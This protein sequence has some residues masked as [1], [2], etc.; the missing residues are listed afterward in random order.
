MGQFLR[1]QR[2]KNVGI[3]EN[4]LDRLKDSFESRVAL[5]NIGKQPNDPAIA[6]LFYIIRFDEKGYRFVNFDDVKKCFREARDVERIVFT[7]D[8]GLNRSSGPIF[9]THC[10]MRFDA[11]DPNACWLSVTADNKDWVD[12]T[13]VNITEVLDGQKTWSRLVRTPWTALLV[14][15]AGV[16]VGFVLSLWAAQKI[17][18]FLSIDNAFVVVLFFS[19]LIY[20]NVWGYIN[21]QIGR[22][23]DFSFPNVRFKR[24]GKDWVHLAVQSAVGGLAITFGAFLIDKMFTLVGTMVA[25]FIK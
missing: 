18:P 22:V 19:L 14:Q 25:S 20:S 17:A 15:L 1:D 9:G 3:D 23:V 6:I 12:V 24:T 21:T 2:L 7:V 11:K 4:T 8:S 13:F 10:D 16:L 5:H